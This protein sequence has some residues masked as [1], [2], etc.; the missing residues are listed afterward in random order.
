MFVIDGTQQLSKFEITTKNQFFYFLQ[1]NKTFRHVLNQFFSGISIQTYFSYFVRQSFLGTKIGFFLGIFFQED[2]MATIFEKYP[3]LL[4]FD[5]TYKMNNLNMPLI[6]Q[7]CV[8][9]NGET[10]I[11]SMFIGRSESRSS[12]GAMIDAFQDFNSAWTKTVVIIGDKDFADRDVYMEKYPD[13]VLQIC[14][15]HVFVAFNR[16]ITTAKRNINK[17]QREAALSILECLAYSSSENSYQT[18]YKELLD[19]NLEEVTKYYNENW[20]GIRE[21]WTQ[22]GRNKYSN[23]LNHTNNRSESINQKFKLISNRY[24]NLLTFFE[25]IVSTVTILASERNIRAVRS[26]M[27]VPRRRFIDENLA[28]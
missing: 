15:Y 8:D 25:N 24:A 4:L 19:L 17:Q 3:E 10:E 23:Y 27:R 11:A 26:T 13:A 7:L 9:G 16:E 14:L 6:L 5:G 21:E 12:V 2:R 22:Y 1:N 28:R 18:Y 20:H